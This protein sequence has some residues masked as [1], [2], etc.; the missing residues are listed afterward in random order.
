MKKLIIL[1]AGLITGTI[2]GIAIAILN[3]KPSTI[4]LKNGKG[5]TTV[6]I[7]FAGQELNYEL[8]EKDFKSIND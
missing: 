8:K 4:I 3:L 6:S 7:E 1:I 2:I 5:K